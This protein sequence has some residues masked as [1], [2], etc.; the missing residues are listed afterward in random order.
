MAGV[1]LA[2]DVVGLRLAAVL[3]G[4]RFAGLR[5][6]AL[7]AADFEVADLVAA[8]RAALSEE[9]RFSNRAM[10]AFVAKPRLATCERRSV[11]T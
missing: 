10:S 2:A 4:V 7:A 9:I 5:L 6:V 8:G 1:R 3:V 11:R